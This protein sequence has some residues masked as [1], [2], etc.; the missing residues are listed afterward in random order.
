MVGGQNRTPFMLWSRQK[1]NHLPIPGIN[2]CN[3]SS[4]ITI[5]GVK[6]PKSM[7][8]RNRGQVELYNIHGEWSGKKYKGE[9]KRERKREKYLSRVDA[10]RV[11][12]HK[13]GVK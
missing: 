9:S 13:C 5:Y 11:M 6:T 8:G 7:Q 2:A 4:R 3:A 10:D 12:N 1:S